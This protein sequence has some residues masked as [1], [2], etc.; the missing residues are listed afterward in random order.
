M[1]DIHALEAH[2]GQAPSAA[3]DHGHPTGWRRYV[4]ST[5]H[6]DIGTM[7]LIFAI[8][9]GIV[10]GAI[11]GIMRVELAEPGIQIFTEG[12][13]VNLFGLVEQTKQSMGLLRRHL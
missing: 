5:N 7:Y 3:H 6:K 11:S 2:G 1:A 12:S 8:I 4:Y 13:V 9:A 10:G